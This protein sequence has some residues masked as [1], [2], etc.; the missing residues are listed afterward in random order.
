MW[1]F[2]RPQA[3]RQAELYPASLLT[4][5]PPG[6]GSLV[7]GPRIPWVEEPYEM[8]ADR[9]IRRKFWEWYWQRYPEGSDSGNQGYGGFSTADMEEAFRAGYD[10]PEC[11]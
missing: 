8:H 2:K 5:F 1:P 3:S 9:M 6:W 7:V 11:F 4:G 10:T